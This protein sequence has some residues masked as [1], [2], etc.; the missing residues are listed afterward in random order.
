M[1]S[2]RKFVRDLKKII[3]ESPPKFILQK[4][5]EK[6]KKKKKKWSSKLDSGSGVNYT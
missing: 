5:I 6:S 2:D 4:N 3:K 1:C